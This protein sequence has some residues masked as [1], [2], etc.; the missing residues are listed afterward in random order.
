MTPCWQARDGESI[1]AGFWVVVSLMGDSSVSIGAWKTLRD[2]RPG[3]T[4]MADS[5]A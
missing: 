1:E 3:L 4:A 5:P 2:G